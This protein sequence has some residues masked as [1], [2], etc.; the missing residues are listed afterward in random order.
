MSSSHKTDHNPCTRIT[1]T[2]TYHGYTFHVTGYWEMSAEGGN[3]A[4]WTITID[5]NQHDGVRIL[6][7]EVETEI[8]R[9]VE[10]RWRRGGNT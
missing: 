8:V 10:G 7:A 5:D 6:D 2:V 3:L 9:R 4:D 1:E